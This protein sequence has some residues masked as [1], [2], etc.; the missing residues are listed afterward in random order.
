[1]SEHRLYIFL[2]I[3]ITLC[4]H[5]ACGYRSE[6]EDTSSA[7]PDPARV[8]AAIT[9][10]DV[11]FKQRQQDIGKL[12]DA[13]STLAK[14]RTSDKRNF[15][16][17]WRFARCSYF[18]GEQSRDKKE[19]EASFT[20]GR[21]AGKIAANL[22]PDKPDGHFWYGAN[23]AELADLSPVTVGLTSVKDIQ[24]AMNRV[25]EIQ[26]DYE[27][28]T[29]YDVLAQI[30]LESHMTGGTPEKAAELLEKA[31]T[32]EKNNVDLHLHLAKAYLQL[33][34]DA[35]AKREL[36]AV[37][38]MKPDP[39]YESEDTDTIAEAKKLLASRF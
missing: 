27:K 38:K 7:A 21:D 30:E 1:M 17:E 5:A 29:A 35:D 19:S 31:L 32:I 13:I 2:T 36:E 20:A 28:A 25:I 39:E 6:P 22:A 11:L 4:I 33:K 16:V 34:R 26:P 23:L 8:S 15:D 14:L 24:A 9:E 3:V 10:S 37:V 12:R 18:L